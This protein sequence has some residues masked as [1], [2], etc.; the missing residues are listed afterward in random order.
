MLLRDHRVASAPFICLPGQD[1]GHILVTGEARVTPVRGGGAFIP[2]SFYRP[3]GLRPKYP[4]NYFGLS[5]ITFPPLPGKYSISHVPSSGNQFANAN[6]ICVQIPIL[7]YE[8][9]KRNGSLK[10]VN[11]NDPNDC[12]SYRVRAPKLLI[13]LAWDS[14][15]DLDLVVTEPQPSGF[16]ISGDN[17]RAPSGGRLQ[18]DFPEFSCTELN[19]TREQVRYLQDHTVTPGQYTVSGF[20]FE[21][22]RKRRTSWSLAVIHNGIT[23]A[24]TRGQSNTFKAKK[25][26][27]KITFTI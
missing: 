18:G 4:S 23:I 19:A 17:Q 22:C 6:D 5:E 16:V 2:I 14:S 11:S 12:I 13:E 20:H 9:F 15:D 1:L 8:L 21:N 24:S 27:F 25:E 7:R 26:I 10:V 3:D